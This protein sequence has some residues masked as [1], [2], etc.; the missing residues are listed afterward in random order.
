[1]EEDG[2]LHAPVLRE[3]F[4]ERVFA[5]HEL[6]TLRAGGL[7]RRAL[8]DFHK[9]AINCSF[10]RTIRRATATGLRSLRL[11]HEWEDLDAFSSWRTAKSR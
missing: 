6:N 4:I 1:M 7:T 10:W 9:A 2:R 8:P 11:P 5:L 3:N